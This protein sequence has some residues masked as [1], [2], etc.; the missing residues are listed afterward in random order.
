MAQADAANT[1]ILTGASSGIGWAL[2]KELAKD[3][4]RVGLVARR[5]DA[6][7]KLALEIRQSGG[8]AEF[9]AADVADRSA[10]RAAIQALEARLGPV[11]LLVANAGIGAP[12]KLEPMNVPETEQMF[13]VNMFG[14]IYA[15]EAVLPG[16]LDRGRGHLAGVS[17][18][19]AYK[20]FPGQA[21]YCAS[22]AAVK[23]YLESLRLQ[24]RGRGIH[25]TCICPGFVK[26]PM[27]EGHRFKMPFLMEADEAARRVARALRRKKKVFNFPW[28]T[29]RLV[30]FCYWVPDWIL[31]RV[32]RGT[33]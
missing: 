17:S 19:A 2:A 8:T 23:S 13:R 22:K 1:A 33:Y 29:E 16:M 32:L 11:E 7:E 28:Q 20:G 21:A 6:L 3:G 30:K 26:T 18:L 15:I 5:A 14:M 24:L 4:Y 31:A 27:T 12:T 25:V 9:A 10:T